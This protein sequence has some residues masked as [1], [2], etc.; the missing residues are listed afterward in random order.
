[1]IQGKKGGVFG[2]KERERGCG[3]DRKFSITAQRKHVVCECVSKKAE[4]KKNE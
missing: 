1:M 4:E 2:Q 3:G